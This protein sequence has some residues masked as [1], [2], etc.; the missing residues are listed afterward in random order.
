MSLPVHC[1]LLSF[2]CSIFLLPWLAGWLAGRSRL[3]ISYFCRSVVFVNQLSG[4]PLQDRS[5]FFKVLPFLP[6]VSD[7]GTVRLDEDEDEDKEQVRWSAKVR[8]NAENIHTHRR[9]RTQTNTHTHKA[10][11]TNHKP[12]R[13]QRDMDRRHIHT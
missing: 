12:Q 6:K 4:F 8:C 2:V 3:S 13:T 7:F 1:F 11:T 5:S 10:H 9:A